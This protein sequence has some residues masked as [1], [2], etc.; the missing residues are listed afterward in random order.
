MLITIRIESHN[1]VRDYHYNYLERFGRQAP[2]RR[3]SLKAVAQPTWTVDR[4]AA[5]HR[6]EE[7]AATTSSEGGAPSTR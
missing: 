7:E 5:V 1:R 3:E 4:P 2:L 6:L